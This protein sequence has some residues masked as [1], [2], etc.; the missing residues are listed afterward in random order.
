MDVLIA[1][2]LVYTATVTP[3]E[4]AFL[5][6]KSSARMTA[7]AATFPVYLLNLL[8]D[9]TF[10]VDLLFNFNLMYADDGASVGL[11]VTD[12]RRIARRYLRGF[13]VVDLLSVIPYHEME[14]GGLKALKLLRLL[15]LFKLLRILRSG[16]ILKRLED[17]VVI[18]Y[19]VLTLCKFVTGTLMIAHWLACMWQLLAR[20]NG[21][22]DDWVGFYYANFVEAGQYSECHA[23]SADRAE[24]LACLELD[25]YDMYVSA[26]Y[27]AIVTMS[28]IGYG[29]IVPTTTGERFYIIF[30]MLIGTSVFAYVVGSVCGIVASMDKKSAEHHDLMDT[31]NAMS[32]E[33]RLGEALQ[34]RLRDYFRYKHTSTN[35]DEWH[36]MLERMSPS[37]RGEVAM[38]QCGKWINNVPFFRGAPD[39]FV[40]DVALK[41]KSVT[42]PQGEEIVRAGAL[43]TRLY[44]VERGV[45]GGKGRVFTSGKTFG[46]EVLNGGEAPTA[47]TA[48]A[49]TYCDVFALEGREIAEIASAF[50]VMQ[51]RL[52]V[53]G[54]RGMMKDAMVAVEHAWR[55]VLRGQARSGGSGDAA[56]GR[57]PRGRRR[58]TARG[59]HLQV[60][61]LAVGRGRADRPR[62]PADLGARSR[63]HRGRAAAAPAPGT[64]TETESGGDA[65]QILAAMAR[66]QSALR[67]RS[68]RSRRGWGRAV[69]STTLVRIHQDTDSEAFTKR[70]HETRFLRLDVRSGFRFGTWPYI[71]SRDTRRHLGHLGLKPCRYS[72]RRIPYDVSPR[73]RPGT[74]HFVRSSRFRA[75]TSRRTRRFPTPPPSPLP[76]KPC[77]A[78]SALC[79][80]PPRSSRAPSPALPPNRCRRTPR[81]SSSPPTRRRTP[82]RRTPPPPPTRK[83]LS[84]RSPPC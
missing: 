14:M 29:D 82:P 57:V 1:V 42:F 51:P 41:L 46:E 68:W 62:L 24:F 34:M 77:P 50:P 65:T 83:S 38:R 5:D 69:E 45:V 80:S 31:L 3:Y 49:M 44:I 20:T 43:S 30:A 84:R 59:P 19:N 74:R 32:R 21:S 63:G 7:D 70:D 4:V 53:A 67:G 33:L 61:R 13:F 75:A 60:R 48:R 18:D 52:R 56:R 76:Q 12:R 23:G 72:S 22:K 39:L 35:M 6:T 16:R 40:V 36:T 15:R 71:V 55:Q 26:L 17:S 81:T 58:Q 78:S 9:I 79:S 25:P 73:L 64:G 37:L 28:T 27:W 54:C 2:A 10:F 47:F 66:M 11:Y 8:V